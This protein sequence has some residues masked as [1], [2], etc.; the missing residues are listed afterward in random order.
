MAGLRRIG[1]LTVG[2]PKD[3][4]RRLCLCCSILTMPL[5]TELAHSRTFPYFGFERQSDASQNGLIDTCTAAAWMKNRPQPVAAKKKGKAK[6][7][8]EVPMRAKN[9]PK[10]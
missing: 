9:A 3:L 1:A 4:P 8:C 10:I 6:E 5:L 7:S 2:S